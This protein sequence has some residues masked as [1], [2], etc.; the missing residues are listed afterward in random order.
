MQ[1]IC[2]RPRKVE[3]DVT[4]ERLTDHRGLTFSMAAARRLGVF[5]LIRDVLQSVA[6]LNRSSRRYRLLVGKDQT[7]FA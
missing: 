6:K 3:L 4:D 7:H 5:A 1:R 2:P